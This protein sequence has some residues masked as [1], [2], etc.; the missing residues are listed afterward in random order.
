MQHWKTIIAVSFL[1]LSVGLFILMVKGENIALAATDSTPP[2]AIPVNCSA[3]TS[4]AI[5]STFSCS[6][7]DNR[8]SFSTVPADHYLLVTDI[9][10]NRNSLATSGNY[11]ATIGQGSGG[12]IPTT[13][14]L[15]LSGTPLTTDVYHFQAPYIILEGGETLSIRNDSSSDF[16]INSYVSGFL[17]TDVTYQVLYQNYLP[18]TIRNEE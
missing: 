9:V 1:I 16:G 17:V 18:I 6:R 7:G 5:T 11:F 3:I 15:T 4:A 14:R 12:I 10:I 8:A 2:N 13:P